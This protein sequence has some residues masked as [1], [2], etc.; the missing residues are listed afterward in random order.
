M[1][2]E[3]LIELILNHSIYYTDEV[4]A[5]NYNDLADA[6]ILELNKDIPDNEDIEN[7]ALDYIDEDSNPFVRKLKRDSYMK[8]AREMRDGDIYVR[9]K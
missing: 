6:L 7:A 4:T 9:T 5:I 3:K 1:T 8:G 2:K